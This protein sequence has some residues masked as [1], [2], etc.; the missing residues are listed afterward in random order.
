MTE[1]KKAKPKKAKV[2][3]LTVKEQA[4]AEAYLVTYN[5][6][7]AARRAG[8]KGNSVTLASIGYENFR[9][10]HIQAYISQRLTEACMSGDEALARLGEQARAN[11]GDFFVLKAWDSKEVFDPFEFDQEVQ[12]QEPMLALQLNYQTVL[13][14]GHLIKSLAW[15]QWGPKLE[16]HDGQTALLNITKHHGLLADQHIIT[17]KVEKEIDEVLD[18]L[19]RVLSKDD[20]ERVLSALSGEPAGQEKVREEA[21]AEKERGAEE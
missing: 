18:V 10:P 17:H 20:Y 6:T 3:K 11:I 14:R 8:Y 12:P 4:W 19:E 5:K 15:T 2:K 1:P 13:E 9:K 16:L 21:G 7:E